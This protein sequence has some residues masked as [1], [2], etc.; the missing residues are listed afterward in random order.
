[1]PQPPFSAIAIHITRW[2]CVAGLAI[3]P[4]WAFQQPLQEA[5]TKADIQVFFT[6]GDD[7]A[8]K[9]IEAIQHADEQV[10]VQAFSF[11]HPGIAE[12]LI[13]AHKRGV[14][15]KLIADLEQTRQ[16]RQNKIVTIAAAG[17]PVWFDDQHQGAHNKVMVID[18]ATA[19][20][21]VITGSYN[22]TNA[23]QYKNA[24]N[25]LLIRGNRNIGK[26]YQDNWQ[27]HLAHAKPFSSVNVEKSRR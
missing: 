26:A 9:I 10:L 15:V 20:T 24:E 6:P 22:F 18:A 1:M 16:L 2:F 4:A 11:T 27:K 13:K 21:V 17:V 23:A 3:A 19:D 14:Q 25:V 7:V 12:A 5:A 8:G